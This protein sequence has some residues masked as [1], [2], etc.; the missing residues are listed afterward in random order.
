MGATH[1]NLVLINSTGP[2]AKIAGQWDDGPALNC[3]LN[4]V[5][6]TA[7][8][9]ATWMRCCVRTDNTEQPILLPIASLGMGLSG[10][11]DEGTNR[12]LLAYLKAQHG[13]L[14]HTFLLTS[15]SA[16]GEIFGVGGWG[17]LIGDGGGGFWVTMRAIKRIFDAEDGLLLSVDLGIDNDSAQ[18]V[19]VKKALLEH[20]AL[21]SKLGLLDILYNPNFNKSLVA[22][23]C[24]KLSEVADGG[25][26]FAAELFSDAGKALA[27]HL[28]SIS[29]HC[30]AEML[31]EL[32][33]VVIGSV[34]K[35]WHFMK[36]GFERH[37]NEANAAMLTKLDRRI[38]R[39]VLYQLECSSAVG[40][41]ILG[42][43]QT[44]C[45]TT[46]ICSFGVLQSK[47][48]FEEFNF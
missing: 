4:G 15:D 46:T 36:S 39:I 37:M 23:F 20:F 19:E 17:H 32:P 45:E 5:E 10:A 35:S 2:S 40:A 30:D 12:R 31:K 6:R 42:A 26:A 14:A 48:V 9:I 34:F 33:V 1:S 43:K 41:A 16:N 27:Q 24:K 44:N 25:D 18:I 21:E 8:Q 38:Y 11:E 47:K 13:D 29:R 22:S 3:L 7:D 28:V